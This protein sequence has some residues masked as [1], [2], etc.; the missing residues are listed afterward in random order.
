MKTMLTF[1]S[2][3]GLYGRRTTFWRAAGKLM[4]REC[5]PTDGDQLSPNKECRSGTSAAFPPSLACLNCLS[6]P[7]FLVAKN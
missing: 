6:C 2:V 3:K 1:D 5:R 4:G 7:L